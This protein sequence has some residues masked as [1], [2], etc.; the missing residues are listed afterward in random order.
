[1]I[2]MGQSVQPFRCICHCRF[3]RIKTFFRLQ[4]VIHHL[5]QHP[6]LHPYLPE[7]ILFHLKA[8]ISTV[9]KRH[10]ITASMILRCFPFRQ[11]GKWIVLVAGG[12]SFTSKTLLS[13]HHRNTL[14]VPLHGMPPVEMQQVKVPAQ[15]IQCTAEC[16]VHIKPPLPGVSHDRTPGDHVQ[17][18][19]YAIFQANLHAQKPVRKQDFDR[20][21]P[22]RAGA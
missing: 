12:S 3:R 7:L 4:R 16:P 22:L 13:V 10:P 18:W 2:N 11:Y 1:M 19:Q 8:E 17:P 15:E 5:V 21:C 9:Q 20:V 6:H 14:H